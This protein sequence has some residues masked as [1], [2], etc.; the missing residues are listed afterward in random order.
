[1]KYERKAKIETNLLAIYARFAEL[2][3]KSRKTN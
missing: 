2:E 3:D 1:M